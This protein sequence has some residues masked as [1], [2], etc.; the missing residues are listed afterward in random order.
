M[1]VR[2]NK[3]Q[4]AK[5]TSGRPKGTKTKAT[6]AIKEAVKAFVESNI[7]NLQKEFDTLEPRDKIYFIEKLLKYYL[8]IPKEEAPEDEVGTVVNINIE[9]L[10]DKDKPKREKL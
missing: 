10:K 1:A 5:G 9:G 4:F 8:P 2:N 6:A 7:N 3:G